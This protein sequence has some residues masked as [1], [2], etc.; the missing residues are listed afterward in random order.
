M[1]ETKWIADI[2]KKSKDPKQKLCVCID[3]IL[4]ATTLVQAHEQIQAYVSQFNTENI[5]FVAS[6]HYREI[7]HSLREAFPNLSIYEMGINLNG[8]T[9][10]P[11]RECL[12]ISDDTKAKTDELLEKTISFSEDQKINLLKNTFLRQER[13]RVLL[14]ELG[15]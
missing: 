3:E 13:D 14:E 12:F 7:V 5:I 8:S 2:V 15:K 11:S 10:R 6:S 9:T 4:N 1:Y